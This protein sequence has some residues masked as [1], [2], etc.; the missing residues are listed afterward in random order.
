MTTNTVTETDHHHH[1][2]EEDKKDLFG[3]WIYIMSD[4][5]VF[6]TLFATFAVFRHN[7]FG[8]A[9]L[10]QLTHLPYVLIETFLLLISSFTCGLAML[11]TYKKKKGQ[12]IGWL[13]LTFF[14]GLG[15][16]LM[17]VNEF[18]HLILAGHGPQSSGAMSAFF[19]LVGTHGFH[20]SMGLLWML[21]LLAQL[22]IYGVTPALR[23]RLTYFALFWAFLDIV[24]IF[25]FTVVY[26]MG[27]M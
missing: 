14:L 24:W 3:F 21:V 10:K 7:T 11:S 1:Q 25:V 23:R 4:C 27:V 18:T 9:G 19:T 15:F 22:G 16:V 12:V 20:V 13:I 17:E 8:H 5:V 26:L 2:A 6:A